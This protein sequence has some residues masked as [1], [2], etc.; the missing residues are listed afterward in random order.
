[1]P[2][3]SLIPVKIFCIHH[4]VEFSFIY[5]LQD[6]G[7]VEMIK[8]EEEYFIPAKQLNELERYVR[9]YR[10][11]E[12]NPEGI[13]VIVHLLQKMKIMQEKINN[14]QNRLTAYELLT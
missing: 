6:Y 10:D 3:V 1:M 4:Q 9:L 2:R 7:M 8:K 5:T 14:L 11:L 13:D 12:I